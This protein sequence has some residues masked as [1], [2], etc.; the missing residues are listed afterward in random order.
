[1]VVV[2]ATSGMGTREMTAD[3]TITVTVTNADEGQSGTVTIGDTMPMVGDALTASITDA[4]DPDGLPDPFAPTWKWYRTPDGGSETE[5]AGETSAAYTVVAADLGATLTAKASWTDKGGFANTLASAPTSAVAA[6]STTPT[7]SIADAAG[8]EGDNVTFTWTLSPPAA[9]TVTATWTAS[10]K[11]GDTAVAADLGTTKTATL[12]IAAD[13]TTGTIDVATTEDMTNEAD[14]TFTMTLSS[15]S[16]NATLGT[17][18]ATGT[19]TNDDAPAAPTD[20]QAGVGDTEVELSWDAPAPAANITGHEFRYKEGAGNYPAAFTPIPT[21]APG[22]TNKAS[23]TV[24]GL[25]NEIAHTFELRAANDVDN[26]TAAESDAVTPTPGICDRTSEV[27]AAIIYFL[28]EAGVTRTCSEVNVA[29]LASLTDPLEMAG[30]SISSLKAGDFAGLTKVQTLELAR[31][32]FTTLPANVFSGMTALTLLKLDAGAL[33]SLPA[34]VFS[35]LTALHTLELNDNDL[36]SLDADVFDGLTALVTLWLH[37]NDLTSLDAGQFTGLTALVTLNLR[38][39]RS[40]VARRRA[41]LG[42][43]GAENSRTEQ[44]R[45]D[46]A[47]RRSVRPPDGAGNAHSEPQR[48]DLVLAPRRGVLGSDVADIPHSGRQRPG[49]AP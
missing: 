35:G 19:I 24:T 27:Q 30:E 26:G 40:D 28:G 41:V 15:V 31:N 37:E 2:Q 9:A 17:A 21:S 3:Q 29:D 39:K 12:T 8:A 22:G 23:F 49:F 16:T 44:Q 13:A 45:S 10:I 14:E 42:P 38:T 47:P 20:F 7:L 46:V 6:A 18:I 5:I 32:N 11:S 33:S 25:T 34:G 43:D 4:A 1:M 36:T 48:P